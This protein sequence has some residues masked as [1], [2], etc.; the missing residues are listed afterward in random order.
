MTS[1]IL[2]I[3]TLAAAAFAI[4]NAVQTTRYARRA[5]DAARGAQAANRQ[6]AGLRAETELWILKRRQR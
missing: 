5:Q 3:V 6:A 4:W 2:G 1:L